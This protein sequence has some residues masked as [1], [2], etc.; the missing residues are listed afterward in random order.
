MR[1]TRLEIVGF[2]S[3]GERT[4]LT[5]QPGIT[6]IVGPNGCGKSNIADAILWCLGEQ[7]AKTLRGDRMD[8]VLFNGNDRR[9]ATGLAE[10][11]LTL[12]GVRP[13]DIEGTPGAYSEVTMTRRLYRS[14]D[15]EYLINHVGCRL[16]DIRDLL[17]E[18]GAGIKGHTILEQ[19]KVDEIVTA[20]PLERRALVEETAG[21][22]KYKI[23]KT[24]AL[25]KLE[26]TEQ[27]LLRV[28]D[29]T[30]EIRR[31]LASL[32]RQVRKAERYRETADKLRALELHT[33]AIRYRD[34]SDKSTSLTAEL[35]RERTESARVMAQVSALDASTETLKTDVA[36][37]EQKLLASQSEFTARETA[38]RDARHRIDVLAAQA[39]EWR[40]QQTTLTRELDELQRSLTARNEEHGRWTAETT[41]L[42]TAINEKTA[43]LTTREEAVRSFEQRLAQAA[44]EI[45]QTRHRVFETLAGVT[46]AS[47]ALTGLGARREE[48]DRRRTRYRDDLSTVQAEIAQKRAGH[49]EL[50]TSYHDQQQSLATQDAERAALRE[51]S[52]NRQ[53]ALQEG[54]AVL[55]GHRNELMRVR[56]T[57]ESLRALQR[58]LV[59]YDESVRRV[60]LGDGSDAPVAGLLGLVAD[61]LDIPVEYER[62]VEAALA[63]RLQGVVADGHD[64][65]LAA[66]VALE[67][68][69]AGRA[70]FVPKAP[71][72][73]LGAMDRAIEGA[74]IHGV[75]A[76]LVGC[77]AGFESLRDALLGTFVIVEDRATARRCWEHAPGAMTWVSLSGDAFYPSGVVHSGTGS[78]AGLSLLERKRTIKSLEQA[79][80]DAEA[81]L[82]PV[83]ASVGALRSA[84]DADRSALEALDA[85]LREGELRLLHDRKAAEA[86]AQELIHLDRRLELLVGE[87]SAVDAELTTMAEEVATH[88]ASL[89]AHE[90]S[91][92]RDETALVHQ[93]E[94]A[95]Q[96][97]AALT[98]EQ[99]ALTDLRLA[100]AAEREKREHASATLRAIMD[101]QDEASRQIAAKE[102]AREQL[103]ARVAAATDDRARLLDAL[104]SLDREVDVLRQ[105][106][107]QTATARAEAAHRV[108]ELEDQSKAARRQADV[109]QERVHALNVAL[110]ETTLRASQQAADILDRYQV[111]LQTVTP[112]ALPP[113]SCEPDQLDAT[114][115]ALKDTL[116]Q[117]GG[118][119]LAAI[120]EYREL[121][122]RARFLA[123]QETDLVQSMDNLRAAIA[124]INATTKTLFLEAFEALNT[125]FGS[126]FAS[127]FEGGHAALHLVDEHNPLESGIEVV[128]QPPGKKLRHIS[129][130]SGG[131]KALTAIALL[132]SSFLIHPSPFCVM[133]EIDAPLDEENVRRFTRALRPMTAHSQFLVVTHNRRTMEQADVLYG[134]TMEE[135][136]VS[137]IVSVKLHSDREDASDVEVETA[138]AELSL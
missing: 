125:R 29:I 16:K 88:H 35:E 117:I 66:L 72:P 43:A 32:D 98:A 21:I 61:V 127:F 112:D 68:H 47:N 104:A 33:A 123:T 67:G 31:Q 89:A 40:A 128:A 69:P 28:R 46:T 55:T 56:A 97:K 37:L 73:V 93:Y 116:V 83:E 110:T 6:A 79:V 124:K 114:I 131:E 108:R 14:G 13:G 12:G 58:D 15:S 136:G 26:A 2:K 4:V 134:V 57:L 133:D 60:L 75:A 82:I 7:S 17:I 129:L 90:A 109:A 137:K 85:E 99:T 118:V 48:L 113:L 121:E 52:V 80:G 115:G 24:E 27:N 111:D 100:L 20:S 105:Q 92:Q 84:L 9:A 53:A 65:V 70:V 135:A 59:G 49:R 19:G 76:R 10:V 130:L 39:E 122:E 71:R 8:D 50:E 18:S 5:F 119:N 126:V 30:G 106:V 23:R 64:Q 96:L 45:E 63:E 41:S 36:D 120:D 86:L 34:W 94:A 1:L 87:E 138:T 78:S 81:A 62:A 22:T 11:S 132:F 107:E 25:R 91:K 95:A 44:A 38:A 103:A 77:R 74:G 102:T 51:V 3:F 54:E 101:R 42:D